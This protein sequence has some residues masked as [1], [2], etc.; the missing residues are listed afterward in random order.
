MKATINE[1]KN[2]IADI[3]IEKEAGDVVELAE[4]RKNQKIS[5]NASSELEFEKQIKEYLK[6]FKSGL[7]AEQ[8]VA[9]SVDFDVKNKV[10]SIFEKVEDVEN[11]EKIDTIEG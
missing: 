5:I 10:Y 7:E 9:K 11:I 4:S 2:G 8:V 3:T 6:A 1:Y